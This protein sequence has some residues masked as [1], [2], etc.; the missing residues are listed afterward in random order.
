MTPWLE[1]SQVR[2]VQVLGNQQ[3]F[4][5]LASSPKPFIRTAYES[6]IDNSFDVMSDC[7]ELAFE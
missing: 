2:K 5:L 7:S 4:F 6:L 3:S 1:L